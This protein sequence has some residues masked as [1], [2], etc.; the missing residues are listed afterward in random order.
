[1]GRFRRGD[2]I[3][4]NITGK[5]RPWLV[6]SNDIGNFHSERVTVVSLTTSETKMR[7][8]LPT[9]CYVE[10]GNIRPSIVCTE[11]VATIVPAYDTQLLEHLPRDIMRD[12]SECLR[13][14]FDVDNRM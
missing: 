5:M 7:K 1:M 4:Q 10:Y 11:E 6:V 2:V 9:H 13:I 12:V 3:W 8:P 14:A